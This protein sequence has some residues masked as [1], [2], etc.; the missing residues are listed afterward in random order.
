VNSLEWVA[1]A[2][3]AIVVIALVAI[4]G[5]YRLLAKAYSEADAKARSRAA[6]SAAGRKSRADEITRKPPPNA[7]EMD[8]WDR[9]DE[10]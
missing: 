4:W 2:V 10:R 7:T 8:A 1:I 9:M 3:S 6:E 5:V